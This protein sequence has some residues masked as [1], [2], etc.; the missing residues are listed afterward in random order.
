MK[1]AFKK[2]KSKMN[3][4]DAVIWEL[5]DK[6]EDQEKK[7]PLRRAF[8]WFGT[9]ASC[10]LAALCILNAAFPANAENIPVAGA[11]FTFVNNIS[12]ENNTEE[13]QPLYALE[14][15]KN[16]EYIGI[17]DTSEGLELTVNEVHC[18]GLDLSISFT[19]EDSENT[20]PNECKSLTLSGAYAEIGDTKLYPTAHSPILYKESDG[21][22]MGYGTF[23]VAELT[24]TEGESEKVT[25]K[26]P[27]L[28]GYK[29]GLTYDKSLSYTFGENFTLSYMFTPDLKS[30][31]VINVNEERDGVTLRKVIVTDTRMD[32]VVNISKDVKYPDCMFIR[33]LTSYGG[34]MLT[35]SGANVDWE[36]DGSYTYYFNLE[37][38]SPETVA[39]DFTL[40]SEATGFDVGDKFTVELGG[41]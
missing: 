16:A 35:C 2:M 37:S 32:I 33:K 10:A 36:L 34:E 9:A 29:D 41:K 5:R 28:S 11:F 26:I 30:Y 4:S 3:P 6:L 21:V 40:Y 38:P 27:T 14:N 18:D 39:F 20:I 15:P 12:K 8:E 24:L 19:L 13:K 22:Y 17:S 25:L 7:F 1:N 31:K 23:N